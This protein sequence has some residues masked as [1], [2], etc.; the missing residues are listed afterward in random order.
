VALKLID[1]AAEEERV[2]CSIPTIDRRNLKD[3]VFRLDGH[4]AWSRDYKKVSLQAA[5][6][7]RRQMYV[8][9]VSGL[10]G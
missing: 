2:V 4:P 10:I 5:E 1:L 8:V 9:D 6:K 3:K 7:G